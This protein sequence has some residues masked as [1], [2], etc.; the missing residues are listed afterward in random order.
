M[1]VWSKKVFIG[2]FSS[3]LIHGT[4]VRMYRTSLGQVL[5]VYAPNSAQRISGAGF[6]SYYGKLVRD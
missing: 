6:T 5:G 3:G 1:R 2:L 4:Y